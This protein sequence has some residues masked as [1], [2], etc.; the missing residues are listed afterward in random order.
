MN[1]NK[2][3][4]RILVRRS[5]VYLQQLYGP[6]VLLLPA[7]LSDLDEHR[8]GMTRVLRLKTG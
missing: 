3:L 2:R 6:A 8:P 1:K 4:Y 5:V 7:Q